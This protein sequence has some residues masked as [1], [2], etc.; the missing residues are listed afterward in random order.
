MAGA[1]KKTKQRDIYIYKWTQKKKGFVPSF[2]FMHPYPPTI[3]L[4]FL[5]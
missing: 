4:P 1:E 3:R 5:H 2:S